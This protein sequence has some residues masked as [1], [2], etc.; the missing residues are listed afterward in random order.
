MLEELCIKCPSCGIVLDVRNSKHE[1]IKRIVCPNCKKQLALD[2]REEPQ[3]R[4]QQKSLGSLYSGE[5]RIEL[6]EGINQIPLSGCEFVQIN[7]VRLSDGTNKCIVSPLTADHPV[8][9]NGK[10]LQFGDKVVLAVGDELLT[11]PTLLVYE[12]PGIA[13]VPIAKPENHTF[14]NPKVVSNTNYNWF[15]GV[16]ACIA[17]TLAVVA[18]WPSAE[19]DPVQAGGGQEVV[20]LEDTIASEQ[21]DNTRIQE[22]KENRKSTPKKPIE[23]PPSRLSDYEL[24]Q[25]ALK[26]DVDAQY[27]LGNKLVRKSG[28]SNVVRG[29]NYLRRASQNGSSKASAV[30]ESAINSL[31]RKAAD[32]D[33]VA[34]R[35]LMSIK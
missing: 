1:A 19:I 14:E 12:K 32:G 25:H 21:R 13:P 11:S 20:V 7:V 34:Y 9:V 6:H 16:I 28:S 18:L 26:G 5:Q 15:Y 23:P 8:A 2:F 24:E 33:S 30:L 17:V 29:I 22:S 35:I 3:K 31:Q 27:E 4:E 10:A